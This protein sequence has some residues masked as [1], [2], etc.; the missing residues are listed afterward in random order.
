LRAGEE[1]AG[2]PELVP[3][4]LVTGW[5]RADPSKAAHNPGVALFG[6]WRIE[7][8]ERRIRRG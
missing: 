6:G 3:L 4:E 8:M 5:S 7:Q 2:L 1:G